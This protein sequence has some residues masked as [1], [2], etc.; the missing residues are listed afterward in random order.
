MKK[1]IA[2]L[3]CLESL[4]IPGSRKPGLNRTA[5]ATRN[6]AASCLRP[7]SGMP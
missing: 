6:V 3:L 5:N 4:F 2:V 1:G 7:R